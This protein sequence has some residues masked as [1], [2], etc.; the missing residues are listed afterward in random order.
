VK[1]YRWVV[2]YDADCGF[3]MWLLAGLLRWDREA[4]LRPLALQDPEAEGL[5]VGLAP[6]VRMASWHLISPSGARQSGGSA[7]PELLALLPGGRIPAAGFERFPEL[8][9]R[10]Y[11]WVADH[12]SRLS[13]LVPASLKRR[14][15]ER[16]RQ[17]EHSS[18]LARA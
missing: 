17:R 1:R 2:V 5:L 15:R 16:V 18:P 11:R 7:L 6:S 13:K 8:T 12:R 10:G 9:D 4:R 3:C 14:A